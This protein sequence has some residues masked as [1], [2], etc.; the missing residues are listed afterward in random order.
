V[1]L[2]PGEREIF[3]PEL[4]QLPSH[5]QSGDGEIG[6]R[7]L[8]PTGQPDGR[9]LAGEA[10]ERRN[11]SERSAMEGS[12]EPGISF[13]RRFSYG[14]TAGDRNVHQMSGRVE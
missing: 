6:Y 10:N 14:G 9:P 1:R 11:C 13:S 3:E 2:P 4:E 8:R 5:A 12:N 7:R